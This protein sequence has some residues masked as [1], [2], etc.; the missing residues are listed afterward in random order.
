MIKPSKLGLYVSIW[1]SDGIW[2]GS[3]NRVSEMGF[4]SVYTILSLYISAEGG[5]ASGHKNNLPVIL[6]I[7]TLKHWVLGQPAFWRCPLRHIFLVPLSFVVTGYFSI[8]LI[9]FDKRSITL[10]KKQFILWNDKK[11]HKAWI[12]RVPKIIKK[13]RRRKESGKK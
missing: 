10:P 3:I 4:I 11:S 13:N 12:Y 5:V 9:F 1:Q 7:F 2:T 8:K 6:I